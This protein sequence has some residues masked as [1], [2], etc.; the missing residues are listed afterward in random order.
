M[1][2]FGLLVLMLCVSFGNAQQLN[3]CL[4]ECFASSA[5]RPFEDSRSGSDTD[6]RDRSESDTDERD[7]SESDRSESR[8]VTP[9][10]STPWNG[11]PVGVLYYPGGLQPYEPDPQSLF[12]MSKMTFRLRI[13]AAYGVYSHFD[14]GADCGWVEAHPRPVRDTSL[15]D[16][17]DCV[18]ESKYYIPGMAQVTSFDIG[19]ASS[20][21][22]EPYVMKLPDDWTGEWVVDPDYFV[23]F[24]YDYVFNWPNS[25]WY[26]NTTCAC[27][28]IDHYPGDQRGLRG[29]HVFIKPGSWA[30][31][32]EIYRLLRV[33]P[34]S[35][36]TLLVQARR[37]GVMEG[38]RIYG[39][40]IIPTEAHP[41]G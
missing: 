1:M 14:G 2:E 31:A 32:R 28:W 23:V 36:D 33:K 4:E 20:R 18:L 10:D 19:D 40:K 25:F 34:L 27:S 9:V 12:D 24:Y 39:W 6:E 37:Y 30:D 11:Y 29:Q 35:L 5:D 22:Y 41:Y 17:L 3:E 13:D 7:R 8:S 15:N 26:S 16:F 21:L 38:G